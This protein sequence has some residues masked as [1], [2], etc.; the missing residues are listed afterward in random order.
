MNTQSQVSETVVRKI[1]KFIWKAVPF[2]VTVLIVGIIILL[3]GRT[4]AAKKAELA[5]QQSREQTVTKPLTNVVTLQIIPGVLKE[6]LSLPGVAKP[7][8][9]LEVVSEIKGKII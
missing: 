7:W 8:I 2:V 3:L 4:I 1:L 5:E 9:S 6:K